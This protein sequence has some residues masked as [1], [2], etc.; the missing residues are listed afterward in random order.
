MKKGFTLA[1]LIGVIVVLALISLVAIPAVS[2][3]LNDN[4]KKLCET[5]LENILTAA[6]SYGADNIFTLPE[7]NGDT[8]EV[9]LQQLVDAGYIKGD[10]DNPMTKEKFDLDDTIV[11][12]T[13]NNKKYDY[14]LDA[15]TIALCTTDEPTV[16]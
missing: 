13:K 6:K 7:N 15:D 4:K 11:V 3:I 10:I 5:Q 12:I 9:T 14:A 8:L 2:S 16:D 1:E